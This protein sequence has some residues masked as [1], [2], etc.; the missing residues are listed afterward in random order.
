M[1]KKKSI[2]SKKKKNIKLP[3]GVVYVKTS[4]NNTIVTLT[5]ENGNKVSGGGTGNMGFKG[6]KK[7]TPYAAEL[8]TKEIVKEAKENYGLKEIG[9][10]VKGVGLGRDGAF[11]AINDVGGVDITYIKE[12]TPIQFGGC[13]GKRPK[14]N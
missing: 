6:T 4:S 14:R 2:A 9:L 5:D 10:I 12:A 7:S 8:L 1:V 13:K 3:V 11:K